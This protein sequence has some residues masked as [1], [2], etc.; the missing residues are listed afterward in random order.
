M[1]EWFVP[2]GGGGPGARA[3]RV[4]RPA[5]AVPGAGLGGPGARA[6]RPRRGRRPRVDVAH[7]RPARIRAELAGTGPREHAV[8]QRFAPRQALRGVGLR[9]F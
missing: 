9:V 6:G 8:E 2:S 5:G 7:R 4:A 1:V 3:R